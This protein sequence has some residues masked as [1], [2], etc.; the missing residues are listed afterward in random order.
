MTT[1]T[2][3]ITTTESLAKEHDTYSNALLAQ[4]ADSLK[5]ISSRYDDFRKRHESLNTKI[6]AER[7][8][9]NNDLKKSKASYD[10]ECKGVEEKRVKVDKSFDSGRAKAE[11]AYSQE[12]T[13]MNN[14][15]VS[16]VLRQEIIGSRG[17]T[18]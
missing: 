6:V 17:G 12:L 11:K 7:E 15:K 4:V 1:W 3:I 9:V 14:I 16:H 2:T 8:S 5:S 18:I 13:E 10:S